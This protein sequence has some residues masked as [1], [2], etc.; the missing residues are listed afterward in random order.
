MYIV[1]RYT[2]IGVRYLGGRRGTWYQH[3][4]KRG[5]RVSDGVTHASS[6]SHSFKKV[7]TR[8]IYIYIVQYSQAN[9]VHG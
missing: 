4:E 8:Y 6:K 3:I 5:I 7:L 1:H 2:I 9:S